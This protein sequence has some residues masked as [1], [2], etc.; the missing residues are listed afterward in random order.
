MAEIQ[1]ELPDAEQ[2]RF[3]NGLANLGGLPP[4]EACWTIRILYSLVVKSAGATQAT[5]ARALMM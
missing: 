1:K 4:A 2:P 5:L 3:A